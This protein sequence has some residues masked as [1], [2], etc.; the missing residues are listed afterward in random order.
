MNIFI[1]YPSIYVRFA[2]NGA[3]F[4][5]TE[6]KNYTVYSEEHIDKVKALENGVIEISEENS[7]DLMPLINKGFGYSISC[8]K[9]PIYLNS[10]N[11][12]SSKEKL[13][14]S[15]V[16]L[17]GANSLSYI[18][19]IS[20]FIDSLSNDFFNNNL[21]TLLDF[22]RNSTCDLR[23]SW[24]IFTQ[25]TFP[26]LREIEIVSALTDRA[27][28][29]A[30]ELQQLGYFVTFRTVVY[31]D[32]E[33]TELTTNISS[34]P[35]ITFKVYLNA[36]L[37]P[38]VHLLPP[39]NVY[40]VY[41]STCLEDIVKNPEYRILP[42]LYNISSQ[43]KLSDAVVL[44]KEDILKSNI[45][46]FQIKYNSLFNTSFM[47]KISLVDNYIFSGGQMICQL[48]EFPEKYSNWLYD[49]KNVWFY[50][51]NKKQICKDCIFCDLCPSVSLM[52]LKGV[53]TV[54]CVIYPEI[55]KYQ[56]E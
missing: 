39:I 5:N 32:V 11:F 20:V 2:K 9:Y 54:P 42:I 43:K 13:A 17:D 8:E 46:S 56:L 53:L 25:N 15:S 4:Y 28:K 51:R 6:D 26:N 21:A 24:L 41:W 44:N 38:L 7:D 33:L 45:S 14:I 48:S 29:F 27:I 34:Y 52:E 12:T 19:R 31:E 49:S 10:I 36:A 35:G 47:G 40:F 3:L 23:P 50:S 37:I 22:P 1:L 16:I 30:Q 55:T 18:D